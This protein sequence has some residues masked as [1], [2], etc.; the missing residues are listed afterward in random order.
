MV[1]DPLAQ[2][3]VMKTPMKTLHELEIRLKDRDYGHDHEA[4]SPGRNRGKMRHLWGGRA[5]LEAL[6]LGRGDQQ[7][8]GS[9]M[10]EPQAP[11]RRSKI[12][13]P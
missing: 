6:A 9:V 2:S 12:T 4:G 8:E 1:N 11:S 7:I 3:T 5:A 10:P 13:P